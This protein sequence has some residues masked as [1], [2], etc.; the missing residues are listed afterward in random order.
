MKYLWI[1]ILGLMVHAVSAQKIQTVNDSL[2]YSIGVIVGQNLI[3]QGINDINADLFAKAISSIMK[4]EETTLS[5]E[6]AQA[7]VLEYQQKKQESM[8]AGV[9][10][11][12]EEF[13]KENAMRPDVVTLESGLQYEVIKE[14]AGQTPGPEDKVK[15]HYHGTLIDGTVFDSSV[16]RGEPAEF[17]LN[18]VIKGWTEVLQHMAVGSKYKVYIPQELAYGSR[19]AGPLIK[20]YSTLIFEIELLEIL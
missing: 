17:K 18:Q 12:G 3:S 10:T 8:N 16:E 6:D 14:G 7:F 4:G 19:G 13:L 1:S 20:P 2:S 5:S 9:K 11:E 15:V